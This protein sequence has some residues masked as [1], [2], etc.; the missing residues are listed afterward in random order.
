MNCY[1]EIM[2]EPQGKE[3]PRFSG[4]GGKI[5]TPPKTVAFEMK[6]ISAF[7]EQC[8]DTYFEQ[9][10]PVKAT[11][12]AGYKVP[13]SASNKKKG[14]MTN[15]FIR[16]TKK[17]DTDNIAKA[18]LDALNGVAYYDDSQ[19]VDLRVLKVYREKPKIMVTLQNE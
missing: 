18:V 12:C 5:Y 15:G 14:D 6:V 19:V 13:A 3:R 1:F 10:V 8:G 16:P 4:R 9:G 17:P 2:T 11:I 7:R